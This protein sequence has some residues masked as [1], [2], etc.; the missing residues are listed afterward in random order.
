VEKAEVSYEKKKS[1]HHLRR[2]KDQRRSTHEEPHSG[3]RSSARRRPR[4]STPH[5]FSRACMTPLDRG[6]LKKPPAA[7]ATPCANQGRMDQ[8]ERNSLVLE[9]AG[10][11]RAGCTSHVR[12]QRARHS[13]RAWRHWRRIATALRPTAASSPW[14][15]SRARSPISTQGRLHE[16]GRRSWLKPFRR[17]RR[18]QVNSFRRQCSP[19]GRA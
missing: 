8:G 4:S 1:A 17:W 7:Q 5:Q 18:K 11:T 15:T 6:A 16:A 13:H 14:T 19:S 3:Q 12:T 10:M 9:I 2:R